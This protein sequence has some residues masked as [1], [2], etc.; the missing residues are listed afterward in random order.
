LRECGVAAGDSHFAFIHPDLVHQQA[1]VFFGECPVLQEFFAYEPGERVDM[2]LLQDVRR[3]GDAL[4]PH[5][6]ALVA[7]E[8][9]REDAAY[10]PGL[11]GIDGEALLALAFVAAGG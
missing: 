3:L 5:R 7:G 8:I 10:D 1:D 2:L 11:G 4:A 6:C 9:E